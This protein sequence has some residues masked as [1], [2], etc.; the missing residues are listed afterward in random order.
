MMT[1]MERA[2]FAERKQT[3]QIQTFQ[4]GANPN[5]LFFSIKLDIFIVNTF[6]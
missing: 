6:F 4:T 2:K 3:I 5:N 1:P